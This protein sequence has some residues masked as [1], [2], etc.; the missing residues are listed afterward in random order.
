MIFQDG[1]LCLSPS[2]SVTKASFRFWLETELNTFHACN[3]SERF[4]M[5]FVFVSET[6]ADQFQAEKLD[7]LL[8]QIS[9]K[10]KRWMSEIEVIAGD[11]YLNAEA[12]HL[13]IDE[14]IKEGDKLSL[15]NSEM[16][17]GY[18]SEEQEE[19]RSLDSAHDPVCVIHKVTQNMVDDMKQEGTDLGYQAGDWS[20]SGGTHENMILSK[21]FKTLE[22]AMDAAKD[23]FGAVRFTA[24]P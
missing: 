5:V 7:K 24:A 13:F 16:L 1:I 2:S 10:T 21:P 15:T 12:I 3:R 17:V 8:K 20:I 9:S 11:H 22:E 4:V 6:F 14:L 18:M 19:P 23:R